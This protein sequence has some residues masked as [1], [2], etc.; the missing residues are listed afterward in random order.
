MKPTT[1]VLRGRAASKVNATLVAKRVV[2][3]N[4]EKLKKA[5]NSRGKGYVLSRGRA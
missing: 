2:N 4:A 3:C 1:T 5:L